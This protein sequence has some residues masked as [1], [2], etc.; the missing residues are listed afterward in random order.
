MKL[1]RVMVSVAV[2]LSC[3]AFQ[4]AGNAGSFKL[5]KIGE[6]RRMVSDVGRY[7]PRSFI[8]NKNIIENISN[9]NSKQ[10]RLFVTDLNT[11]TRLWEMDLPMADIL[12]VFLDKDR[13]YLMNYLFR[14]SETYRSNIKEE[15][16]CFIY[17]INALSGNIIWRRDENGLCTYD[18]TMKYDNSS[19]YVTI[20]KQLFCIDKRTGKT[21]WSIR[22]DNNV[23]TEMC[24]FDSKNRSFSY[25][26][27]SNENTVIKWF[28]VYESADWGYSNKIC[29][30]SKDGKKTWSFETKN[31]GYSAITQSRQDA[32]G[33]VLWMC[34]DKESN[35]FESTMLSL[36]GSS[37]KVIW[38]KKICIGCSAQ[39]LWHSPL[40]GLYFFAILDSCLIYRCKAN[41]D[42]IILDRK[43]GNMVRTMKTYSSV[44]QS[45]E[46]DQIYIANFKGIEAVNALTGKRIWYKPILLCD[47]NISSE[48]SFESKIFEQDNKLFVLTDQGL[49]C[50]DA[51]NGKTLDS[52]N[53]KVTP[54]S[55]FSAGKN[56]VA[57][58]IVNVE[59]NP[60]V[61]LF[62]Y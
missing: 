61:L 8:L 19:L 9:I 39:D 58:G 62:E 6:Y 2:L 48:Y 53:Y 59:G 35:D 14:R 41:D 7:A 28:D 36:D 31:H 45:E 24:N 23:Y 32:R 25:V 20:G 18:T 4:P 33:Y 17:C 21:K 60:T 34:K 44:I 40:I 54:K 1:L 50:I 27:T 56:L 15:E 13:L 42:F 12:W 47:K 22:F 51:Q 30:I 11:G 37:G 10:S 3:L 55:V 16:T 52:W 57:C 29:H 43:T 5:K 38:K 26:S 46:K 49:T